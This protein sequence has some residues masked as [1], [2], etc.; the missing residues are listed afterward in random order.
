[1]NLSEQNIDKN[2]LTAR[3]GMENLITCSKCQCIYDIRYLSE[4]C[5]FELDA[6]YR[7][8]NCNTIL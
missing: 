6:G 1:M 4:S 8:M 5:R 7:C 2:I 3:K